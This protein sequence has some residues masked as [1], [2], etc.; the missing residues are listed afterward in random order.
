[1]IR[2]TKTYYLLRYLDGHYYGPWSLLYSW[3]EAWKRLTPPSWGL[4]QP[5]LLLQA[6]SAHTYPRSTFG[7]TDESPLLRSSFREC[8]WSVDRSFATPSRRNGT[9]Q[10]RAPRPPPR[11][12]FSSVC[13][14]H[15]APD[16]LHNAPPPPSRNNSLA[17]LSPL[18]ERQRGLKR[19]TPWRV[20]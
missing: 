9:A 10:Q 5:L 20:I 7:C 1:M 13:A 14:A 17:F 4:R 2:H 11:P 15:S 12:S 18:S 19:I 6:P 8:D 3:V 16:L